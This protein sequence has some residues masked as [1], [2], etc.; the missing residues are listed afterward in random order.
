MTIIIVNNEHCAADCPGS[1]WSF[2][3]DKYIAFSTHQSTQP[4]PPRSRGRQSVLGKEQLRFGNVGVRDLPVKARG[5]SKEGHGFNLAVKG[6][7]EIPSDMA[8]EK[9]RVSGTYRCCMYEVDILA[10]AARLPCAAWW[11]R[12]FLR[13]IIGW[14]WD[15]G[16]EETCKWS[17]VE[18]GQ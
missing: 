9:P 8:T 3:L 10:G 12:M 13:R 1:R 15:G 7:V 5:E 6:A 18:I 2:V 17:R 16:L 14:D 4:S 11:S